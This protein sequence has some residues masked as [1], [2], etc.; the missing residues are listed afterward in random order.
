MSRLSPAKRARIQSANDLV[1]DLLGK[2]LPAHEVIDEL[3]ESGLADQ[4]FRNGT[5][6]LVC[7]GI[8]GETASGTS[9]L[10][11]SSWRRKAMAQLFKPEGEP[12]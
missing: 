6:Q 12:S 1:L 5:H 11:L 8:V 3:I 7:A 4:R 9:E 10:M 2:G